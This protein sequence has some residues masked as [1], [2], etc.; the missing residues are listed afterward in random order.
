MEHSEEK[1]NRQYKDSIFVELLNFSKINI[2]DV[3]NAL[4]N[5]HLTDPSKVRYL[6]LKNSIYTT[7]R[8][9]VACVVDGRVVLLMEHQS[10]INE[11][12]PLRCLMYAGRLYEGLIS[13]NE[14]YARKLV[15][16]P[17][18]EF[19][20]F[21]NGK[22]AYPERKTLRLSDAFIMRS[23]KV[24]LELNVEV[25]NINQGQNAEFLK[26]CRILNEYSQFVFYVRTF[27]E[28][29]G[30]DGFRRAIMH[31]IEHNILKDFLEAN[32]SEVHNFLIAEYDYDTDI[33]VQRN[34]AY[35]MGVEK[36]IE[37]G[38]ERGREEGREEGRA[39]G[40]EEERWT[41]T[42]ILARSFRDMGV[43]LDKIAQA[44]GLTIDEIK[45]L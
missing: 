12:M 19:Y 10:T 18:P 45:K 42:L 24:T 16:I 13:S 2:L 25:I 32:M 7:I 17:T 21:Y 43:S 27:Y 35:E 44:T 23:G 4:N 26:H 8:N 1:P 38:I 36:G 41:R 37:Q 31:S 22:E 33:S 29:D 6:S 20:V 40:R 34:E 28:S 14:R 9:D 11:N 5:S 3:Y 39:E 15:K 30:V